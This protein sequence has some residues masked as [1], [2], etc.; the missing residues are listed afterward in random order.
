MTLEY[1]PYIMCVFVIVIGV[2]GIAVN[3][4]YFKKLI[5]LGIMQAGVIVFFISVAK[6]Q[7]ASAPVMDCLNFDKCGK[8]VANPLPHVLMLTAIV[9][10]F[11]TLAV[12]LSLVVRIKNEY[13][14][15]EDKELETE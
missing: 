7:N 2:Y 8:L 12:G 10:G 14:T 1:L 11:A 5:S 15:I 6:V 13:N 3:G 4:N 9:V